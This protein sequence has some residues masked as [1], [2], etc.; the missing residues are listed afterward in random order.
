VHSRSIRS[1]S[2]LLVL[3]FTIGLFA[4]PEASAASRT[5]S[6]A[7]DGIWSK[8]TNWVGGVVPVAG[9]SLIFP[10]G[11]AN[12][13][14]TNDLG[15]GFSVLGVLVDGSYAFTGHSITL[16][17][18]GIGCSSAGTVN[19]GINI[20]LAATVT[21]EVENPCG[22][23][24]AGAIS[25]AFNITKTG[26]GLVQLHGANSFTGTMTINDGYIGAYSSG[27]LGAGDG[28]A[29]TGTTVNTNGTLQVG[30]DIA[31]EAITVYGQGNNNNGVLQAADGTFTLGGPLT[32][33]D[34]NVR[35]LVIDGRELIFNGVV[36]GSGRFGIGGSGTFT[37]GNT[38]NSFTG[39]TDFGGSALL[40]LGASNVIPDATQLV[41]TTGSGR[42]DLN[43]FDETIAGIS[44]SVNVLVRA[45]STLTINQATD[46]SF[47]GRFYDTGIVVKAGPGRLTLPFEHFITGTMSSFAGELIINGNMP[48]SA[49]VAP[50]GVIG[51]TGTIGQGLF[52]T[53]GTVAPGTSPGILN[54]AG[55][56]L[57]GASTLAVELN[58]ATPGTGY[59]QL[60][61]TGAVSVGGTLSI[62]LGYA[63][64]VGDTFRIIDNDGGD[65]VIGTFSGLAEGALIVVGSTPMIISYVGGTGNDV[66]LTAG[67]AVP[68]M[69]AWAMV[70]LMLGV[71]M[72]AMRRLRM[73]GASPAVY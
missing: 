28:T 31:N 65:A 29:L 50:G 71:V 55:L 48:G 52:G 54:T 42:F 46:A 16:G 58:G 57:S 4:A 69:T 9:D 1:R 51:G 27:A 26:D 33:G 47:S 22:M 56:S 43:G 32:F 12:K 11:G 2:T 5:W 63:P 21:I 24:V 45:A 15:N 36:G 25:G 41:F 61:V 59:D 68:S 30:S 17:S 49:T 8:T 3:V 39:P 73:R 13:T 20:I 14:M 38:G 37:L 7:T 18:G 72:V 44:G 23:Q 35:M 60:A 19:V 64:T 34:Q 6:G 70:L 40:K 67:T 66:V 53:G 10:S 62:N